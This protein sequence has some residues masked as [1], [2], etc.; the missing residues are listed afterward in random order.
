MSAI[1]QLYTSFVSMKRETE[2]AKLRGPTKNHTSIWTQTSDDEDDDGDDTDEQDD[3]DGTGD[4]KDNG[5]NNGD[6]F[7][8]ISNIENF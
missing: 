3:G 5:D 1:I 7:V 2:L 8:F 4:G 6:R